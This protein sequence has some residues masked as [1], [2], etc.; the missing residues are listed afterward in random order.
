M[1]LY[2][3]WVNSQFVCFISINYDKYLKILNSLPI[4]GR[5]LRQAYGK[6]RNDDMDFMLS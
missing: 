4:A 6:V 1:C 2:F 3:L 5:L